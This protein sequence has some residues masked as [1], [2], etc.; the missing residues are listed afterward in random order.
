MGDWNLQFRP[1]LRTFNGSIAKSIVMEKEPVKQNANSMDAPTGQSMEGTRSMPPAQFVPV[2]GTP[3]PNLGANA[4]ASP[5][6]ASPEAA[7]TGEGGVPVDTAAR[8][9]AVARAG[10]YVTANPGKTYGFTPTISPP[11]GKIDCSGLVRA[12]VMAAGYPDPFLDPVTGLYNAGM[13]KEDGTG[14]WQNGVA[15]LVSNP[16]W[17]SKPLNEVISGDMVTFSTTRTNHQGEGGKYDHI[18]I[19]NKITA[20]E[21]GK[22]ASFTFIHSSSGNGPSDGTYNIAKPPSWMTASGAYSWDNPV[23][24]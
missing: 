24:K 13:P 19:V 10:E 7:A 22:V 21:D 1:Q 15:V 20:G 8:S 14:N 9:A 2:A 4:T 5:V 12:A 23:R 18:G 11:G 6:A 16:N 17:V 3:D